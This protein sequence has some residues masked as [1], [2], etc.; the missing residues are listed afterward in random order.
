MRPRDVAR[1]KAL[2][3]RRECRRMKPGGVDDKARAHRHR[4]GTADLDPVAP[5][6]G[7]DA[8]D[9]FDRRA[10][11]D[12][13]ARMF[14]IALQRKHQ[15]MAVDDAARRRKQRRIAAQ[16]G[17][18]R[19]RL[20]GAQQREIVDAVRACALHESFQRGNL[21]GRGRDDE[22][23]AATVGDA[24]R[25]AVR[26]ELLASGDAQPGLQRPRRVVEPGMDHFA[27]A[28]TGAGADSVLAL[29]DERLQALPRKRARDREA[30]D[31]GADHD[32]IDAVHIQS[33]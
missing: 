4:L 31:P 14:E 2:E 9:A 7:P 24:V 23:S 25:R 28:R 12:G 16:L 27:V 32:R 13:A 11:H 6:V 20:C 17:F 21:F 33:A 8:H 1:V 26:V 15:R 30:D 10:Q 29:D 5:I 19:N 22:L 3:A 18:E